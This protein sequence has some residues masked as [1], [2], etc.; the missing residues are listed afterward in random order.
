MAFGHPSA[1]SL[2]KAVNE[3]ELPRVGIGVRTDAKER[4]GQRFDRIDV[5]DA[6]R[7]PS[8]GP[9]RRALA[10][11]LIDED[12]FDPRTRRSVPVGLD[13]TLASLVADSKDGPAPDRLAE[14]SI[15][16]GRS[17]SSPLPYGS[18]DDV[19]ALDHC[20][21]LPEPDDIPTCGPKGRVDG[22]VT[23]NVASELRLPVVEVDLRLPSVLRASV[24]EAAIDEHCDS[25]SLEG[26]VGA[27]PSA[28]GFD[29]EVHPEPEPPSVQFAAER[30]LGLGIPARAAPHRR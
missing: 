29:R 26:D 5:R 30:E 11:P 4:R 9:A 27:N 22:A 2:C 19:R 7:L 20:L 23:L 25:L 18:L 1:A 28:P 10:G 16:H 14:P 12:H 3:A 15:N 24:P 6:E 8:L 21:V 17:R 13:N